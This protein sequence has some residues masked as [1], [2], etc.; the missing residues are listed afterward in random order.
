MS[1][2]GK[3]DESIQRKKRNKMGRQA[4]MGWRTAKMTNS[5]VREV[6]SLDL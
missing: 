1:W 4:R 5:E 2:I 6:R 3:P